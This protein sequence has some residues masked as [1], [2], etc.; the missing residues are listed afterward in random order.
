MIGNI[1]VD[2]STDLI[3]K[4]K[5]KAICKH[6]WVYDSFFFRKG[7]SIWAYHCEK[8]CLVYAKELIGE[9]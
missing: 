8:C 3:I 6:R 1:G 5:K 9:E 4:G 2:Y 7:N